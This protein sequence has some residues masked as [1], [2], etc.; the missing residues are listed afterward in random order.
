MSASSGAKSQM[1]SSWFHTGH[2]V[3]SM[4]LVWNR[5]QGLPTTSQTQ[6]GSDSRK[7]AQSDLG[8]SRALRIMT[9]SFAAS[10]TAEVSLLSRLSRAPFASMGTLTADGL[11]GR[12]ALAGAACLACSASKALNHSVASSCV[13]ARSRVFWP[14]AKKTHSLLLTSSLRSAMSWR[15]VW[16]FDCSCCESSTAN[17]TSPSCSRRKYFGSHLPTIPEPLLSKVPSMRGAMGPGGESLG[18]RRAAGASRERG[19]GARP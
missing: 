6:Y 14:P 2:K 17:E 15:G 13:L 1:A 3:L 11:A 8:R 19:T 5:V 18:G 16:I 4:T 7:P 12:A 10:G 9:L